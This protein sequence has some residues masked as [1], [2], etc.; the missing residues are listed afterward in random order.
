[1]STR[2]SW[3]GS[4]LA[5]R[6]AER[7]SQLVDAAVTLL[8]EGGGPACSVRAVC[9]TAGLT[10]RYFYESF[11]DRDTLVAT[12]F[13]EL[14]AQV[15]EAVLLA[16]AATDGTPEAVA[17]AAVDAAVGLTL[18]QPEKGRV[19]FVALVSDPILYGKIDEFGPILAGLIRTQ[20][21]G[22]V[23]DE[24]A[25]LVASSLAGALGH[26][27]HQYV[28]G[29]LDVS[30][31]AFVRHCVDVLLTVAAMPAPTTTTTASR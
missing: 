8:A 9:R 27:F 21:P 11:S 31:E 1:M 28:V 5:D 14:V 13:D 15:T 24:H 17:T 3:A 6:K 25:D 29:S 10:E 19:L 20:L 23:G 12:V 7:R 30:R 16:V 4:T 2:K 22:D 26:L 18:D